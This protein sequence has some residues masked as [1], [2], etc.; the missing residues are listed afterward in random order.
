MA[1][2]RKKYRERPKKVGA[3]KRYRINLHKKKLIAAGMKAEDL[4]QLN[5]GEIRRGLRLIGKK[6]KP[7][8]VLIKDKKK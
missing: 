5:E 4:S 2:P 3:K 6:K 7:T 8:L 1:G